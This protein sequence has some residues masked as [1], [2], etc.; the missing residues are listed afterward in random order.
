[1]KQSLHRIAISLVL[2]IL[3]GSVAFASGKSKHVTFNEDVK[4]G[5]TIVKKGTYTV[6]FDEKT[7]EL[8]IRDYKKIVAKTTARIGERQSANWRPVNYVT[9][10]DKESNLMLSG[11]PMGGNM[12]IVGGETAAGTTSASPATPQQ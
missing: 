7:N 9:A 8:T 3:F 5:D 2:G 1:M 12:I 11:I 4:V 6:T 10:K